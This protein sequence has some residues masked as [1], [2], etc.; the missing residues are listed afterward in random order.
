MHSAP[1]RN[2]SDFQLRYFIANNC[3]TPDMAW[4]ILYEQ[5]LDIMTKLEATKA[6]R[7]RREAKGIE[8]QQAANTPNLSRLDQLRL[9]ADLI[10]FRSG[11]GL[12]ELAIQG[13]EAELATIEGLMA[14][15][16]PQRKYAHLPVLQASEAAQREEWLGEFKK[17]CENYLISTGT[18][19]EDHLNA[20]RNHP[21][22]E[23]EIVPHVQ[24][25]AL[26]LESSKDRL[27]MLKG[28]STP[29]LEHKP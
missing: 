15:L 24:E 10:E 25:I 8:L 13:A 23:A 1:H 9:E 2:N 18:I 6:R 21:D 29:L 20:M 22:F 27:S 12:L 28:Y 17:R 7:L 19:P 5:R 4:C 11:E 26:K 14:E 3:S 16:T